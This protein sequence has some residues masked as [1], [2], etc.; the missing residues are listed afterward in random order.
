[1]A[2]IAISKQV[3]NLLCRVG[4]ERFAPL[5]AAYYR[6]AD[7]CILVYDVTS[8]PTFER[9]T[10]W[11]D[12]F[13][14]KADP[15]DPNAFPFIIV[16]NKTD[17]REGRVVSPRQVRDFAAVWAKQRADEEAAKPLRGVVGD[18]SGEQHRF[19]VPCYEASAKDGVNV[20]RVFEE[21][22]RIVRMPQLE[23]DLSQST[24]GEGGAFRSIWDAVG[25]DNGGGSDVRMAADDGVYA[26]DWTFRLAHGAPGNTRHRR[27]R[28]PPRERYGNRC[29]GY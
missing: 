11:R 17:L 16:G 23:L 4:Q 10:Y 29:C 12:E 19:A 26:D 27:R 14:Q 22:T 18:V 13:L 9:L 3:A 6:G 24:S 21:L 7:A 2:A 8:Y 1:M 28:P 5:G 25:T 20:A 15:P